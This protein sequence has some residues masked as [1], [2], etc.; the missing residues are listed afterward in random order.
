M[1]YQS[2]SPNAHLFSSEFTPFILSLSI[3]SYPTLLSAVSFV[4]APLSFLLV[5]CLNTASL[6]P[7]TM[8]LLFSPLSSDFFLSSS[9]IFS[10]SF[11][12]VGTVVDLFG[13]LEFINNTAPQDEAVLR[14]LSFG[15][16]RLRR[17]LN[18][19]FIGN[20]G[21]CGRECDAVV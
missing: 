17:G 2:V 16:V 4:W 9:L 6:Y 21:R 15:Q 7:R 12:V 20:V 11:Q 5:P 13:T 8:L 19:T 10:P 14:L 1:K 18:V 3:I